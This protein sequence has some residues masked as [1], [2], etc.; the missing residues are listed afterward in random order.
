MHTE[1]IN[2][3]SINL[4]RLPSRT[5]LYIP[6]W[7]WTFLWR[8]QL[9]YKI[10]WFYSQGNVGHSLCSSP[11]IW[12]QLEHVQLFHMLTSFRIG[13]ERGRELSLSLSE[14]FPVAH[15]LWVEC[16]LAM[17]ILSIL[18]TPL[19]M[20][21]HHRA[22]SVMIRLRVSLGIACQSK[23]HMGGE[24]WQ[25]RCITEKMNCRK[26]SKSCDRGKGEDLSCMKTYGTRRK[27][28]LSRQGAECTAPTC[29]GRGCPA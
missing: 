6:V 4:V 22:P 27:T 19:S 12:I 8:R 16:P 21:K 9:N 10:I 1:S 14:S 29:W 15:M 17:M 3:L 26:S 5:K 23:C 18:A 20:E 7:R 11:F 13:C 2:Y 25:A 24:H 28:P